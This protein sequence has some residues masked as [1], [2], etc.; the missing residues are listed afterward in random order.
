MVTYPVDMAA[1]DVVR[2]LRACVQVE[3]GQPELN[4]A[5]EIDYII[6]EEFDP[7]PYGLEKPEQYDLV[8]SIAKLSIEP[9][10]E[11][12]YWI[13]EVTVERKLGPRLISQENEFALR[14]LT[15]DEFE[16]ELR[17]PGD[18]RVAVN[19]HVQSPDIVQDFQAWLA[20]ASAAR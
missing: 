19:L 9:R 3:Q 12:G 8:T 6:Q 15:L 18:R 11:D 13:L 4:T 20:K 17:E 16:A 1:E 10:V 5:A 2:L 7:E 14:E